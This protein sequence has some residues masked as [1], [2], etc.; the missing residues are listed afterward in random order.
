MDEK[1]K[2]EHNLE[3]AG[4]TLGQVF[5]VSKYDKNADR[6]NS[7]WK[8]VK[9]IILIAI[10]AFCFIYFIVAMFNGGLQLR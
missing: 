8:T 3:N 2:N 10:I 4:N 7:T 6:S 1:K 5:T 9:R